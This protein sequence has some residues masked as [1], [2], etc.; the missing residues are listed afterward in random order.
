MAKQFYAQIDIHATPQRVWQLL[1][2]FAAYPDWNPFITR[3]S[4]SARVEQEGPAALRICR[5]AERLG[6][7]APSLYKHLPDKA[8][9]RPPS[10]P[11]GRGR[12][13]HLPRQRWTRGR[14]LA[15][16]TAA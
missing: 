14:P 5:L 2:D 7:R 12:R 16:F 11:P 8:A 4:G 10:S 1:T 13:R 3:S 9:W 15:A 6:I